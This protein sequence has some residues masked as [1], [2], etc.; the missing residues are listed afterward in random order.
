METKAIIGKQYQVIKKLGS[1]SFGDIY[2]GNNI[3]NSNE[4]VAIKCE[5]SS[6]RRPQL[7]YEFQ[8]YSLFNSKMKSSSNKV[9]GVPYVL[10]YGVI[11]DYNSLFLFTIIIQYINALLT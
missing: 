1:G 6:I 8:L 9:V 2:L 4:N 3:N 7:K 10:F 11:D 5:N